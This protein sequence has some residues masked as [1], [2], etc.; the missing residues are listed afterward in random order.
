MEEMREK[1]LRERVKHFREREGEREIH[2]RERVAERGRAREIERQRDILR[3]REFARD[4]SGD[5]RRI[6]RRNR[7][8]GR[9][10]DRRKEEHSSC[11]RSNSRKLRYEGNKW[12]LEGGE[13]G[14]QSTLRGMLEQEHDVNE[15]WLWEK[16]KTWGDVREVFIA[17]RCNKEGRRFGFGRFK[18]V[19][20]VKILETHLDNIFIDDHKLFVNLPRFTRLASNLQTHTRVDKGGKQNKEDVKGLP[21][22][23]RP[24]VVG[25]KG[26][27]GGTMTGADGTPTITIEPTK[28]RDFWCKGAWVGKLKKPMKM[29]KMEDYISWELGY[30]ISTRFLGDDMVLLI[31]L[32]EDQ[33]QQ[34]INSEINGGN[35]LFY[36]LERWRPGYR[37]SNRV[38]WLQLWGFPIE[39][40]E[41]DHMKHIVSTIGDVIEADED[42]EDR[43]RLDRARLLVRTPLPP[44]IS[45]EV[46]VRCGGED[47]RVWLVEEVGVDGDAWRTKTSMSEEWTEEITSE[48]EG[49]DAEEDDDDTSFSYS[50]ELSATNNK[51]SSNHQS[52]DLPSGFYGQSRN[53]VD[54]VDNNPFFDACKHSAGDAARH[55]QDSTLA[56]VDQRTAGAE[57]KQ[58]NISSEVITLDPVIVGP[59]KAEEDQD[60]KFLNSEEAAR[61]Q[62]NI[63]GAY[64]TCATDTRYYHDISQTQGQKEI[65]PSSI[66]GPIKILEECKKKKHIILTQASK[67]NMDW[68]PKVYARQRHAPS[69][70]CLLMPVAEENTSL[71][72]DKADPGLKD[73]LF[74]GTNRSNTV[75]MEEINSV[76]GNSLEEFEEANQQWILAK[77]LGLQHESDQDETKKEYLDKATC[78]FLWGQSDLAWEW[79][80]AIHAAGGL[81][82]IWDNNKFQVD[83]RCSDKDYIMLGGVWLPQMQRVVVINLYAPCDT[84]G[85]RQLWQNL[86]NRKS[87][88][89]DPCWCLAGDFNCIRYSSERMGINN[90]N[91]DSQIIEEFND[92][93]ADM[94]VEDIPCLGKPFTW[95]RPNGT[96]KSKLDRILV[97]DGWLDLWPD[98]SQFNLERNYSDHCPILLQSKTSDWGPKPFKVFDGWLKIKEFQQVVKEC[99]S[100]Y[101]PLGWGVLP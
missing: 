100:D 20:D 66:S 9:D 15:V 28:G 34:L 91:T 101:Q 93:I 3:E 58:G 77:S 82:C 65:G 51:A 76:D 6:C 68:F 41:V 63:Q 71:M 99:W 73:N 42:T 81:L 44:A 18:G 53:R 13:P 54:P 75:E 23:N 61:N 98:S 52:N 86:S 87:R 39:A 1:H 4:R 62:I 22:T 55:V 92:W 46:K 25:Q 37:S 79:Q 33:A 8:R 12:K 17:K 2:L 32:S 40:W 97:S 49:V 50:S 60:G 67:R 57:K 96:C 29:E 45:K 31:G 88:S 69:K 59:R 38:V 78:Q 94:E 83:F 89:L 27:S 85:K 95:V 24:R 70:G 5:N 19:S 30:N 16:F 74:K 21:V 48:E 72:E 90:T 84:A 35:T 43:R 36:S 47:H 7:E 14:T 64:K 11:R 80:P 10:R 56:K 26:V